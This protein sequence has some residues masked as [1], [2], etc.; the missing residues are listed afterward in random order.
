V[1]IVD[2]DPDTR[3]MYRVVLNAR[4]FRVLD[5]H[6][7]TEALSAVAECVPD[8]IV[9]E[10]SIPQAEALDLLVRFRTEPRT[11]GIPVIVLTGWTDAPTHE[12]ATRAGAAAIVTKPCLPEALV[13]TIAR[14]LGGTEGIGS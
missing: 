7:A 1:L 13:M 4:G 14:V 8:V 3:E 11:A 5:A 12:R 6:G 10:V 9:A 2:H